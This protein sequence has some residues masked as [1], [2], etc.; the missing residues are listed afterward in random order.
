MIVRYAVAM[1]WKPRSRGLDRTI[2]EL[3]RVTATVLVIA[4]G[5]PGLAPILDPD[6][7]A[8]A[9]D[10]VV[11]LARQPRG[12]HT[13]CLVGSAQSHAE[14]PLG[15]NARGRRISRISSATYFGTE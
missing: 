6:R 12:G 9:H 7:V 5:D 15:A 3:Q 11:I 8:S 10:F 4:T 14:A 13:A 1:L 2:E